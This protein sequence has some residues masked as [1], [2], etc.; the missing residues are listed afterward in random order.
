MNKQYDI[1]KIARM[2]EGFRNLPT[3]KWDQGFG[4]LYSQDGDYT[5][6]ED[7][8]C[9]ACV[10]AWMDLFIGLGN[11]ASFPTCE[12]VYYHYDSGVNKAAALL[13]TS[14][15]NLCSTLYCNGAPISP[16]GAD[17]WLDGDLSPLETPYHILCATVKELTGYDHKSA[18]DEAPI[19]V[20]MEVFLPVDN[21]IQVK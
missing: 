13:G 2:L 3:M 1:P 9:G 11:S 10:G 8:E 5:G 19:A 14:V 6:D 4:E 12:R 7:G 21:M 16:F 20:P 15:S 17:A 18:A